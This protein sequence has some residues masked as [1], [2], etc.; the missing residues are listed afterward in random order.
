MGTM[1]LT[2]R[3]TS[4]G[5]SWQEL[6]TDR[7]LGPSVSTQTKKKNAKLETRTLN[8]VVLIVLSL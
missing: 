4:S 2:D 5:G 7:S 8:R 1:T 6:L 3:S